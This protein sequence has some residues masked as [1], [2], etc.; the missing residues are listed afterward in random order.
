MAENIENRQ[1]FAMITLYM[2]KCKHEL[3]YAMVLRTAG[4][5]SC[6]C[7]KDALLR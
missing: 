6:L 2:T 4:E 3:F 1:F 7:E 5:Q